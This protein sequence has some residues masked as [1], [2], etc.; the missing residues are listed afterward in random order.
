ML[1]V[2]GTLFLENCVAPVLEPD[3]AITVELPIPRPGPLGYLQ[4]AFCNR[5]LQDVIGIAPTR[6][7]L[8]NRHLNIDDKL[9]KLFR[10]RVYVRVD[11]FG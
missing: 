8:L 1:S 6:K 9:L 7:V 2:N 10:H 5:F 4:I 3:A 11:W